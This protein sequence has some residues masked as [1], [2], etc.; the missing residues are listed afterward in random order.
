MRWRRHFI[1]K[2]GL[3]IELIQSLE[4]SVFRITTWPDIHIYKKRESCISGTVYYTK[5][6]YFLHEGLVAVRQ[7]IQMQV[8][9]CAVPLHGYQLK[10]T[11]EI[12]CIL[13]RSVSFSRPSNHTITYQ[14]GN[15]KTITETS[16]RCLEIRPAIIGFQLL[17]VGG[18]VLK[19][20]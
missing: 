17:G 2:D 9:V 12:A 8:D 4:L 1:I 18:C 19:I 5:K 3:S 14:T 15:G 13:R 7:A 16:H 10:I 11:A 6:W 20:R